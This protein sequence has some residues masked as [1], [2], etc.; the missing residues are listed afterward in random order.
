MH[1]KPK[2]NMRILFGIIILISGIFY[3]IHLTKDKKS[4]AADNL[5]DIEK[6]KVNTANFIGDIKLPAGYKRIEENGFGNWLHKLKLSKDKSLYLYNHTLSK[7]QHGHY[8]VL[9]VPYNYERLQQ[10]AD[11]VIR[12]RAEY[13]YETKQQ[14]NIS[15]LHQHGKYFSIPASCTRRQFEKYLYNV[16]AWCGSYNLEEQMKK[17][18]IQNIKA[19]NV[20]VR[21]G[22]PGHAMIVADVAENE[23]GERIF[24]LM[25]SFMPAQNIHIVKNLKD[26]T[27]SPWYKQTDTIFTPGYTFYANNLK[28]W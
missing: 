13:L 27:L 3:G 24:L 8:A 16:F 28:S 1:L 17:T 23:K 10:C 15:F 25:Q 11:A 9:D 22:S 5:V 18:G 12:L 6:A 21:G 19:G 4:A 14:A 26:K 2:T 20:F 7:Y